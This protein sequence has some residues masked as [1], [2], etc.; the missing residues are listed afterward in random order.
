MFYFEKS[1]GFGLILIFLAACTVNPPDVSE[2]TPVPGPTLTPTAPLT[3]IETADQ[4]IQ[5]LAKGDMTR[6]ASFV[7]PQKGVRFSPYTYVREDHQVFMP[8]ELAGMMDSGQVFLWGSY[9]G[10][11]K[12]IEM[13]FEAYY[14]AFVYPVDYAS[15]EEV[16]VNEEIG[17]SSMTNNI[18][19][20]YPQSQFVEYHFS[21]FDPQYGGLD[22]TS[23]RL[24]F[25]Q[26]DGV[27]YLVGVV[28]DGWTI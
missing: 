22:W 20:F 15:P 13:T 17:V 16:G 28:H 1:L 10:S 9:D 18:E 24:V 11:G 12:P 26:E 23:L 14:E 3:L 25:L 8:D 19:D 2:A 5:I 4:V 7:H 21:G 6:L 27:W